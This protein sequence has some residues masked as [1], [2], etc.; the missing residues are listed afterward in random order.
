[1][2]EV[3][4][5]KLTG[6]TLPGVQEGLFH[7]VTKSGWGASPPTLSGCHGCFLLMY[8]S[9]PLLTPAGCWFLE[10]AI[11]LPWSS[12]RFPIPGSVH[13]LVPMT[14]PAVTLRTA[15]APVTWHVG[16]PLYLAAAQDG[17]HT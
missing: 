16:Y 7:H 17:S 10:Q 6:S 11:A 9:T 5:L 8:I 14:L 15:P 3:I 2:R 1:M 12:M 13:T 4:F